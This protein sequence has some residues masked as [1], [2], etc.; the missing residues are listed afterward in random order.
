MSK[1]YTMSLIALGFLALTAAVFGQSVKRQDVV[2]AR[3]TNGAK[4]TLDGKFN[5]PAWAKAESLVVKYGNSK[6]L[7][8]SGWRAE[9]QPDAVTDPTNAVVKFLVDGNNL[10]LGFSIPDSSIGGTKDW[11][12]WDAVLMSIKDKSSSSRP[13]PAAEFFYT[14]WM[15]GLGDTGTSWVGRPPRFVGKF[16]D[17][18]GTG[19]TPA[20]IQA[21]D[22]VTF[23]DGIANDNKPDKGWYTEMRIDLTA[24]G[25]DVTKADGDIVELNFSIWD[26]DNIFGTDPS[27]VSETRTHWQSPWGNAN[28]NNVGRIYSKPSVTINTASLPE[29]APDVIIPNGAKVAAPT[30]DG[31]LSEPCWKGAYTFNIAWDD[32]IVRAKYP[33]V[34]PYQ[35]GQWQP[36]LVTG[37]RPPVLDPS[38]A[39]VK[40]FFRDNY[41]YLGAEIN[42]QI[43]QGTEV[44]DKV[45]GIGLILGDRVSLNAENAMDFRL[46]RTNFGMD[47]KPAAYDFLPSLVDSGYAQYA[48][49]LKGKTT[50]NTNTDV[51]SGYVI[52]MKI[53][54]TKL[55]YAKDLGDHLLFGGVCLYDG[56]SFDDPA[57]NYGT[58]TWWFRETSG[59]PATPWMYMD[60][61]SFI[62]AVEKDKESVIPNSLVLNG[63][64]PNPF[65]PAT[66][67]S[68]SAPFSGVAS[69]A[70]YNQLGQLVSKINAVPVMAGQNKFDFNA[71]GLASGAYFY[72][73]KMNASTGETFESS[74]GKMLL[75][76]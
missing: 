60:P 63:N 47:G 25:Y 64:Y 71:S 30:I 29:V 13:L 76:K 35:S 73:I 24:L 31:S 1:L 32:T 36:E 41:L 72:Q 53:D 48:I 9:F 68:Y 45:D 38:Y 46:L 7:P 51:D 66:K 74:I 23:V 16:G 55:G 33:G 2:W 10:Y 65:N 67:I 75:L 69:L 70:V 43:V 39:T 21:W 54:L 22:A 57:N 42:D 62:T 20:A 37:Q 11:A 6:A 61:N 59:G 27:T 56:D 58:R 15:A 12:R 4:I 49:K 5:E 8:T 3:T 34:G 50:V 18:D 14:W 17:W 19:R 40:L 28:G 44:Y 26:G 52:E